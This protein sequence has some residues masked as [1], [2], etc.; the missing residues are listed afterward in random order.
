[1]KLVKWKEKYLGNNITNLTKKDDKS[2]VILTK[3]VNFKIRALLNSRNRLPPLQMDL[4]KKTVVVD[5]LAS[6]STKATES[7]KKT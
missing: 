2:S 1:M 5:N 7:P 6:A 3:N 4:I